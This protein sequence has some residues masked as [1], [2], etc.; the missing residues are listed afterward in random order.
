MKV[1]MVGRP[2]LQTDLLLSLVRDRLTADC[3]LFSDGDFPLDVNAATLYVL[4]LAV[5]GFTACAEALNALNSRG[6]LRAA[7][8]NADTH[9]NQA[10]L[11][12]LPG[13]CGLFS[14]DTC[15]EAFIRGIKAIMTGEY[16]LPRRVLCEHLEQ[17]RHVHRPR[18]LENSVKLSNKERQLLSL[19]T[20]GCS[21]D[22]IAIRLA[23]S[24]HTVKTH[25]YNLYRK[26]Q[27]RNRVQAATWA[28]QNSEFLLGA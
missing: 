1:I 6:I 12:A 3:R 11:A 26:L 9:P 27:V 23:I 15:A 13:V 28:Q 10:Q 16:W 4:D 14:R 18:A 5:L 24:P 2:D 20:Q 7:V 8:I 17:T 25:F 19:L 21:N 22:A